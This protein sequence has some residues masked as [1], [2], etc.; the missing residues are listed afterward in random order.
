[1]GKNHH[2]GKGKWLTPIAF[3]AMHMLAEY[4]TFSVRNMIAFAKINMPRFELILIGA[5]ISGIGLGIGGLAHHIQS[6][7]KK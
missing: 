1:M 3:G 7:R 2:L 4:A 5:V 6:N